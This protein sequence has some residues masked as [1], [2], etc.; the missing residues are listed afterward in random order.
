MANVNIEG[1]DELIRSLEKANLFDDETT[2]E[3]LNAGADIITESI[4][5]E[6]MKSNFTIQHLIS[7]I[8]KSKIKKTKQGDP[9][10]SITV[11][12]KNAYGVRNAVILFV[13]NYG[14]DKKYGEING[15][16]FW[17]KGSRNCEKAITKALTKIAE[18][19]LKKEGL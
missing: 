1:M 6:M 4:S 7:K 17:T 10:I 13:L 2:K 19:K 12:G 14:R 11:K 18:E 9:K 15:G 16:Y 3:M 5:K 8:K